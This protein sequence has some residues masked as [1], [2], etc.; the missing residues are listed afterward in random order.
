MNVKKKIVIKNNEVEGLDFS[1][2]ENGNDRRRRNSITQK[3]R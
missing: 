3:T 1:L 2:R